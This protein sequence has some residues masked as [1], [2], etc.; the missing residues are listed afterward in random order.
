[1]KKNQLIRIANELI[2]IKA[3]GTFRH[4]DTVTKIGKFSLEEALRKGFA[5]IDLPEKQKEEFI[6]EIMKFS[7]S[8]FVEYNW[9][10]VTES[11]EEW[12]ERVSKEDQELVEFF[13]LDKYKWERMEKIVKLFQAFQKE[14]MFDHTLLMK[15][16]EVFAIL[17]ESVASNK[18][19][20][21]NEK[22]R[23]IRRMDQFINIL[24]TEILEKAVN[25]EAVLTRFQ[26]VNREEIPVSI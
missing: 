22:N 13:D 20:R 3:V 23:T 21:N 9:K 8:L 18:K 1:M 17:S 5:Q 24:A 11:L 15:T 12:K 4:S 7:E 16:G 2:G 25:K 19:L 6:S 26:N 14:N 10:G